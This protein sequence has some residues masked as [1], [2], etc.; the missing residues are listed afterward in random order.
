MAKLTTEKRNSL[1][2]STF[3]GPR[4]SFPIPNVSHARNALARASDASPSV[5]E[6]VRAEVH[7]RFPQIDKDKK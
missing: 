7:R 6:M 3:A 2:A 4:R 5:K 1:P